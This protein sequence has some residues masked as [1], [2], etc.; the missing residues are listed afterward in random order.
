MNE[1]N[2]YQW[3]VCVICMTFNQSN[4][5]TDA[6]KGFTMQQTDFPYV[7]CIV[8]DCSTDGEQEVIKQYLQ[9][10]FDLKDKSVVRNEETDDYFLT[11]AQHKVNKNCYFA[12]LYLKYNHYRKKSKLPYYEEW[13]N[14]AKYIAMCEGD[15]FWIADDKL[16]R[17]VDFLDSHLDFS[18][19]FHN[20]NVLSEDETKL[21][22]KLYSHLL[23]KEYD[24]NEIIRHWTVPTC[25]VVY[26]SDILRYRPS[27]KDF[28]VG[29][30][31]LFLTA[32]SR[33]RCYCFNRK[34]GVYRRS[35]NGWIAN[36]FGN[37]ES[38]YIYVESHYKMIKHMKALL[39]YFP[40]YKSGIKSD[41]ASRLVKITI[42]QLKESNLSFVRTLFSGLWHYHY[43]YL[44]Y[45]IRRFKNSPHYLFISFRN[46]FK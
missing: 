32:A 45:V 31:V 2:P 28:C 3:Q 29:D 34:M 16:Q 20:V 30:N 27:D 12:V 9:D 13:Q 8:D 5:I 14:S 25:S 24:G 10:N 33:G 17:Q 44:Y 41:I 43:Y 22:T 18:L 39:H 38:H 21:G 11:F 1:K 36:K 23:E 6:M 42:L 40:Q 26:R 7:C 19:C 35:L 37:V 4:Y 15:D 46:I